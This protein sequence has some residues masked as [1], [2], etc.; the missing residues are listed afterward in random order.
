MKQKNLITAVIAAAVLILLPFHAF[1]F[2]EKT[3]FDT[4]EKSLVITNVS[5]VFDF[6]AAPA[7]VF[8][9]NY[10]NKTADAKMAMTEYLLTVFQ[11]GVQLQNTILPDE[12]YS[13]LSDNYLTQIKDGTS[14]DFIEAF[15]LRDVTTELEINISDSLF[16]GTTQTYLLP[17]TGGVPAETTAAQE[18]AEA[19]E[20]AE[21]DWEAKYYS[22]ME[23]YNALQVKYAALLEAANE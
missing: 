19:Q 9:M 2:E 16:G 6:E 12:K 15:S 4:D 18:G 17:L 5:Y 1:A 22:L 20:P 13:E 3:V 8:E 14:I 10:T 21:E 11:N 7:V 23:K